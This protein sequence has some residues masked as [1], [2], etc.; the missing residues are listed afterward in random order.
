MLL[1]CFL[2]VHNLTTT[3]QKAFILG[4]YVPYRVGFDS[5]PKDPRFFAR[6]WARDQI[7]VHLENEV[8]LL[9][10]F[11]IKIASRQKHLYVDQM[12]IGGFT[13][14]LWYPTQG[15]MP[16]VEAKGRNLDFF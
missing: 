1:L 11:H 13:F 16:R 15:S 14:I 8:I 9:L 7:L 10:R 12:Y 2:E 4:Q 3:Y 6:G 5:L